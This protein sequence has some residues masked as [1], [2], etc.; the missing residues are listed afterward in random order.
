M[1][2][3]DQDDAQQTVFWVVGAVLTILL[4]ALIAWKLMATPVSASAGVSAPPA[5][6]PSMASLETGTQ[7]EVAPISPEAALPMSLG[8]L[9]MSFAADS[10]LTLS[11][12][13]PTERKKERLLGQAQLVF[14][15]N[16]VVDQLSVSKSAKMPNWKG[17]TLDLMA[18]LA[19]LGAF[20]L[21]L[22][23]DQVSLAA[24]VPDDAI[25]SAWIDWLANFFVD[26][27]LAVDAEQ[28]SVNSALPPQYSFGVSTLFNLP[29]N[30]ETGS[31]QISAD[32]EPTL[33]KVATILREQSQ[34][35]RI[36]GHTDASGDA[37][38][39]R[40]LSEARAEAVRNFLMQNGVLQNR[41]SAYG[42]GQDQPIADN[43]TEAGRARNRRIEFAQ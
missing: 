19:Q 28:L 12:A 36:I 34:N 21:A 43:D 5:E 40:T 24:E 8:E 38:A 18:H 3:N 35:V 26:Y 27:P 2:A 7:I 14:G 17:T 30:F 25:K 6:T 16:R 4:G 31:A 32:A 42:M 39:N 22:K 20:K 23:N 1:M 37:G 33:L 15:E 9:E 10:G 13:V 11:G 41:M 29:V